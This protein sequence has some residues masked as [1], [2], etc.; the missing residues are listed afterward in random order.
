MILTTPY[1]LIGNG[2]TFSSSV[3]PV[4]DQAFRFWRCQDANGN[5]FNVVDQS[6]TTFSV[7]GS[8]YPKLTSMQFYLAFTPTERMKIKLLA[9]TGIPANSPLLGGSNAAIP[10]DP[11]IAEFWATYEL[12]TQVNG[13]VDPNLVSVQE[14][15]TYLVTPTAPTPPVLASASR[16]AQIQ[17]GIAQ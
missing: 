15:L 16:I 10:Q 14:G 11:I 5:P 7:G 6:G 1:T 13:P 3:Q 8:I 2:Q 17:S 9:T 12:S 4:Y